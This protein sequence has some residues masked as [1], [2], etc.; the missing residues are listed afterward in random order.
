MM[1][2]KT[3]RK[4][5]GQMTPTHT[6][7]TRLAPFDLKRHLAQFFSFASQDPNTTKI[8]QESFCRRVFLFLFSFL[9]RNQKHFSIL[10]SS[11]TRCRVLVF[12]QSFLFTFVCSITFLFLFDGSIWTYFTPFPIHS[13][14]F[15]EQHQLILCTSLFFSHP[16]VINPTFLKT[17]VM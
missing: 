14:A 17:F 2:T 3:R 5:A 4:T 12:F 13:M 10:P 16:H 7:S 1:G 6:Q 9:N 15:H 11:K 8:L